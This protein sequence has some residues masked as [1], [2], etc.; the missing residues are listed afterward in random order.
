MSPGHSDWTGLISLNPINWGHCLS[1]SWRWGGE[2]LIGKKQRWG[3]GSR[4]SLRV[5]SG[6]HWLGLTLKKCLCSFYSPGKQRACQHMGKRDAQIIPS[7]EK[8]A[9]YQLPLHTV[10][11]LFQNILYRGES[12]ICVSVKG[13]VRPFLFWRCTRACMSIKSRRYLHESWPFSFMCLHWL[14]ARLSP[15]D[16]VFK[17]RPVFIQGNS[18][19]IAHSVWVQKDLIHCC[20][21]PSGCPDLSSAQR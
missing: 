16:G 20:G 15:P 11:P 6:V 13:Q 9:F 2:Q 1:L 7:V 12:P 4:V 10:E 14:L 3:W 18:L 19:W 8:P 5:V 17:T 21:G